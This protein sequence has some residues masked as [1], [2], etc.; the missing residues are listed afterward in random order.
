MLDPQAL[1]NHILREDNPHWTRA[2][3]LGITIP[4]YPI[5]TEE[6]LSEAVVGERYVLNHQIKTAFFPALAKRLG[7]MDENNQ[8]LVEINISYEEMREYLWI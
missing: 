6:E 1:F 3:E 4:N 8:P 7:Y 5:A 2:R